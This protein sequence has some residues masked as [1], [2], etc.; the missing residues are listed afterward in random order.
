MEVDV[1]VF[2]SISSVPFPVLFSPVQSHQVVV[3]VLLW[4]GLLVV[5]ASYGLF[6]FRWI[7]GNVC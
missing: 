2:V 4:I 7:L 3:V 5:D 1:R 6:V